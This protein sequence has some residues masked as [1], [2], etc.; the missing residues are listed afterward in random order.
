MSE[1][2]DQLI[3]FITNALDALPAEIIVIVISSFP[4]LELRAGLPVAL[5]NGMSF[6]KGYWLSVVGNMLPVIPLLLLFRP[7]S[8]ILMRFR[9]Y[10]RFYHW[11]YRRTMHKSEKVE[12]YG[13]LGLILFTAVP[14]PTTGAWTACVAASLFN[15]RFSYAFSAILAGVLMAGLLVGAAYGIVTFPF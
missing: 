12:R 8:E 4:I 10:A 1:L 2:K 9:W 3:S 13:A 15:I 6:W 7:L 5:A 14:L 11:L